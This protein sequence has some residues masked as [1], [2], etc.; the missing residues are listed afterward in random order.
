M[1]LSIYPIRGKGDFLIGAEGNVNLNPKIELFRVKDDLGN[2]DK[3]GD[4]FLEY[5]C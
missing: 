4:T 2:K 5:D 1:E 3:E